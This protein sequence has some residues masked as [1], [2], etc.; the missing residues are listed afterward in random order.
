[1]VIVL[2]ALAL[3]DVSLYPLI[4]FPLVALMAVPSCFLLGIFIRKL[5]LARKYLIKRRQ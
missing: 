3:Q 5:P 2:V 4:K 1:M